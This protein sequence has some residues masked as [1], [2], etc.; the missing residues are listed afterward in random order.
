MYNCITFPFKLNL[1]CQFRVPRGT[2]SV[3]AFLG[4]P[5]S[6]RPQEARELRAQQAAIASRLQTEMITP[7]ERDDATA[8]LVGKPQLWNS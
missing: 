2:V 8:V 1:G 4:V 5:H 6:L 7:D 3:E